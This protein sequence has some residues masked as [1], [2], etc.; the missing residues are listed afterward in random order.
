MKRGHE[1]TTTLIEQ[2]FD[3]F[4]H[5]RMCAFKPEAWE[6]KALEH[7]LRAGEI[8][9][10]LPGLYARRAYWDGLSREEKLLHAVKTEGILHPAWVFTHATAAFAHG[11]EASRSL[12]WPIHYATTRSCDGRA[13]PHHVHH[14][15]EDIRSVRV[16][17][18][19]VTD[20]AQTAVDC[21]RT[22]PFGEALSIADSVLHLQK[23][24]QSDLIDLLA[25][26]PG[27]R[28]NVRARRVIELAD[29]RPESGGESLVRALMIELGLP[30]PE[31]QVEIPD[32]EMPGHVH[33]VDFLF[34][35]SDASPVI[36]ELDGLEKYQNAAMTGGRTA[37]QVMAR[38][39]QREAA[40]TARGYRVARI[41][42]AQAMDPAFLLSRLAIY[43]I[44]PVTAA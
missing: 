4:E 14:R 21:A 33:R 38:E 8:V 40:L 6:R 28:G 2:A 5:A 43:G 23:A 34:R 15:R 41:G 18:I 3:D 7:R 16:G 24:A 13:A 1:L 9:R 31:L 20:P 17:G 27:R 37:V 36:L 22:L 39:R 42:F 19:K 25:A 30:A 32:A 12:L 44:R 10:P 26:Q 11:L 29:P 35:P